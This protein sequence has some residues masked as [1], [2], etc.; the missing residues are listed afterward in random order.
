VT[1]GIRINGAY[2]PSKKA[3]KEAVAMAVRTKDLSR[4]TIGSLMA[5]RV[6]LVATSIFGNEYDGDVLKAPD[7]FYTFVGPDENTR[8]NFFGQVIVKGG[9]VTIK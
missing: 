7:G 1:Q 4:T 5:P 3:V 9:K 8:R 2:A 6:T